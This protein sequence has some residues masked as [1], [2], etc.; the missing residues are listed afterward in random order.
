MTDDD[1]GQT[2]TITGPYGP[3][4][5]WYEIGFAHGR[6]GRPATN[7]EDETYMNGWADGRLL[8]SNTQHDTSPKEG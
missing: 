1:F 3:G 8:L 4:H 5:P 2:I 7:R 6:E